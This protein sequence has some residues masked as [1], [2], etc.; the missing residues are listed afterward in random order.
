MKTISVGELRQN[1][2]QMLDDVAA[3]ETYVV[4]RHSREVARIVPT[5]SSATVLPPKM[6]GPSRTVGLQRVE[7]PDGLD[8]QDF[9]EDLKG[10]W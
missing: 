10:E 3:G 7:L 5:V 9:L 4:T 8:M 2:T 1:P 6:T